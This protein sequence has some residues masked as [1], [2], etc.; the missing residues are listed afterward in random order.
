MPVE[1]GTTTSAPAARKTINATTSVRV[2][3]G[4]P[5]P[6]RRVVSFFGSHDGDP[7]RVLILVLLVIAIALVAP[8]FF[9]QAS[10]IATSQAATVITLLAIGQTFVIISGGIDLSVG[11]IL[12]CSAMVGAVI[13]RSMTTAGID[14][15][16]TITVGFAA[17]L[18]TGS[19]MGLVN[20][21]VITKMGITP[22][23]VT[24]GMMGVGTGVTNLLS[25]GTEVV[26][27]PPELSAIGNTGLLAGWVTIP[28]IVTIIV[29]VV[30]GL[31]LART[32]FGLRTYAIGSNSGGA[33]RTGINVDR[34]LIG[35]YVLTGLLSSIAGIL[36]VSRFVGAS[37][38]AG[39]GTELAAIAA[40]V[41]G[42]AS[43]TGGR[44]S[45]I[46]TVVGAAITA[47]LQIGLILAGVQSFW[48][49]VAIGI[50]IVLAVYGDQL[51][52]RVAR[53][54]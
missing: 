17:S 2:E 23:I 51:R 13:M 52:I 53:D 44:G 9:S 40:A 39:Q 48:Q 16:A 6:W 28:V 50:V 19:L 45:I 42:G 47:V 10:W 32:R 33:R 20:G 21:L 27:L 12:A 36:L 29:A 22:F 30:A 4:P 3:S 26:G 54:R 25:G 31:V 1:T 49:T 37:P 14:P 8:A 46:G 7:A 18:V 38:L 41:I 15:A 34:H 11:A 35:V 5:A 24:L 43:L